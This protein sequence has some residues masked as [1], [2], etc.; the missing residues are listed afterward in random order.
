MYLVHDFHNKIK[1]RGLTS[2]WKYVKHYNQQQEWSATAKYINA[3]G[4]MVV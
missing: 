1:Y 3:T 2:K 4:V